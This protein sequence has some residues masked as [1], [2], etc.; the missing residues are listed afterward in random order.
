MKKIIFIIN[1]KSADINNITENKILSLLN[2]NIFDPIIFFTKNKTEAEDILEKYSTEKYFVAGGGDGTVNFISSKIINT[3]KLLFILPLGSG[4]STARYLGIPLG[5]N[6]LKILNDHRYIKSDIIS[7][8]EK[9]SLSVSGIGLDAEIARKFEHLKIRGL[10][11]YILISLISYFKYSTFNTEIKINNSSKLVCENNILFISLAN[12][13]Q[14][15]N[16]AII[17]P[18][19]NIADGI[20]NL[21]IF[22]K[23]PIYKIPLMLIYLFS[24]KIKKSKYY[25]SF[26]CKKIEIVTNKPVLSHVDGEALNEAKDKYHAEIKDFINL[27]F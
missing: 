16:N 5:I 27:I 14:F 23:P 19:A 4:N 25:K 7:F 21:S 9:K 18:D 1:K 12:T 17:A 22:K 11:S 10:K 2:K 6:S 15:G 13:N 20:I 8:E 26:L 24:G 3:N